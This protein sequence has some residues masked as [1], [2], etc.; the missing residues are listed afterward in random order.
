MSQCADSALK[1]TID[2]SWSGQFITAGVN[3]PNRWRA[4]WTAQAPGNVLISL[5]Y[6]RAAHATTGPVRRESLNMGP[7]LF[8][9]LATQRC[10]NCQREIRWWDRRAWIDSN[11][12]V[13]LRCQDAQSFFNQVMAQNF[14][15]VQDEARK[16]R[17]IADRR[18]AAKVT[19]R[20]ILPIPDEEAEALL[21]ELMGSPGNEACKE[22][23]VDGRGPVANDVREPP[24]SVTQPEQV[25]RVSVLPPAAEL[26][27]EIH[28][29][30]S[31]GS[32]EL[33]QSAAAPEESHPEAAL[34]PIEADRLPG[35]HPVAFDE[36]SPVGSA[37]TLSIGRQLTQIHERLYYLREHLRNDLEMGAEFSA[38]AGWLRRASV[39]S[40]SILLLGG[41]V[42]HFGSLKG[43]PEPLSIP[44]WTISRFSATA[45]TFYTATGIEASSLLSRWWPSDADSAVASTAAGPVLRIY[46]DFDRDTL[47]PESEPVLKEMAEI[48]SQHPDW[49]FSL[50]GHT[51]NIGPFAYN[52]DLSNRRAAVVKRTLIERYHV[53]PDRLTTQ[54]FAYTRPLQSNSTRQGRV[55]NRRVELVD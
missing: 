25:E 30:Q 4:R 2:P 54:G 46:F 55:H 38:E 50:T 28:F 26:E 20:H 36:D 47:R 45:H 32:A 15:H 11:L 27:T 34:E 18:P 41:L 19:A 52:L 31:Q 9:R 3:L 48:L 39:A 5:C 44:T 13:H 10:S 22:S 29:D 8:S 14:L 1:W 24:A 16:K 33:S 42:M 51:D 7:S 37:E 6:L 17:A 12:C 35:G 40:A 49:K 53:A 23:A 21:H 43:L